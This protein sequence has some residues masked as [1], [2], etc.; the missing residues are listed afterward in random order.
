MLGIPTVAEAPF[1]PISDEKRQACRKMIGEAEI[2]VVTPVPIGKGNLANLELALEAA[3][4]GKSVY[5]LGGDPH[6][7]DF[8]GGRGAELWRQ[9]VER[10]AVEIGN[11]AALERELSRTP[12]IE[13]KDG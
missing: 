1:S 9:L 7:R 10:G 3:I 5:L 4:S 6:E 2:L 8:S 12:L 13:A 11:L